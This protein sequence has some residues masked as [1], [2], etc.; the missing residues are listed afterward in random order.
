MIFVLTTCTTVL[1]KEREF[2]NTLNEMTAVYEKHGAKPV[3]FWWT[4]GGERNEAVWM[5]AWKD[6]N[7]YENGQEKAVTDE[8]YP[9]EQMASLIITYTDK[10]L[11]PQKNLEGLIKTL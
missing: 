3:G 2:E 6:V 4:L 5:Y 8:N 9:L 1:G 10:I 11:K 7:A